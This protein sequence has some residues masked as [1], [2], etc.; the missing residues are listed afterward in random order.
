MT[1]QKQR[2]LPP[3]R[4]N[5]RKVVGKRQAP[6]PTPAPLPG[7]QL[8]ALRGRLEAFCTGFDWYLD[9]AERVRRAHLRLELVGLDDDEID[10]LTAEAGEFATVVRQLSWV[11]RR[12]A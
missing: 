9:L 6:P 5:G 8:A 7:Q 11:R 3:A 10:D 12:A 2:P 4:G 1:S